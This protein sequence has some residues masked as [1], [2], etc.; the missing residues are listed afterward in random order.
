MA[1]YYPCHL[2]LSNDILLQQRHQV[3]AVSHISVISGSLRKNVYEASELMDEA[4][5]RE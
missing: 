3:P 1:D 2:A 4:A 5:Q